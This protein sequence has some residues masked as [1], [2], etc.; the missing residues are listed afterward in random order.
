MQRKI[1][2]FCIVQILY[3][4]FLFIVEEQLNKCAQIIHVELRYASKVFDFPVYSTTTSTTASTGVRSVHLLFHF[5]RYSRTA[6]VPGKV[7][8][9]SQ[10]SHFP[11]LIFEFP[12]NLISNHVRTYN[13]FIAIPSCEQRVW[14]KLF[15]KM[16]DS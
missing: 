5:S 10:Q 11:E 12:Y 3:Y 4:N 16:E 6:F 13:V 8:P 14:E 7:V 9:L 1:I 2:T 15:W